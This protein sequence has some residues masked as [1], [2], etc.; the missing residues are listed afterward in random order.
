MQTR[1]S[2]N[3]D[4]WTK[5]EP[6]EDLT[7]YGNGPVSKE[8]DDEPPYPATWW[9]GIHVVDNAENLS[10]E[11]DFGLGP[12]AILVEFAPTIDSLSD[13]PDPVVQGDTL[14]LTANNVINVD[15]GIWNVQFF[16]DANGNSSIDGADDVLGTDTSSDGGW[17]WTGSTDWF[18]TGTNTYMARALDL[19]G[20]CSNTVIAT[21]TVNPPDTAP[22]AANDSYSTNEDTPLTVAA[23]GV[24]G[25]DTDMDGDPLTA[26]LVARPGHG[27]LKPEFQRVVHL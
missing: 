7:S 1:R 17:T 10:T 14:T 21:G 6:V 2:K 27:T 18:P 13:T 11:Y 8:Y 19:F 12:D 24:L 16:R 5:L 15:D 20:L 3:A 22:V 25:N 9:Y 4:D 26:V 23:P